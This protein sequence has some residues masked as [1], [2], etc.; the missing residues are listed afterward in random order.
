[1][2]ERP[3]LLWLLLVLLP[4]SLILW[5]RYFTGKRDLKSVGGD[6]LKIE[7]ENVYIVKWFFHAFFFILFVFFAI[8]SLAGPKWGS[9]P[10][11]D[12]RKGQEIL[13]LF[14]ISNSML[15]EDIAP[16]RLRRSAALARSLVDSAPTARYGV[17]GFKGHG[18]LLLPITEDLTAVQNVLESI[19][20]DMISSPG[21]NIELGI[22]ASLDSFTTIFE[23]HKYLVIFTDGEYQTGD[24]VD[25]APSVKD[26]QVDLHVVAIGTDEPTPIPL[27]SGEYM[28]DGSGNILT[29]TLRL[30]FWRLSPLRQEVL[31]ILPQIRAHE[32]TSSQRFP[33]WTSI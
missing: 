2:I 24:P 25:A 22:R 19:G 18:S 13:F 15:A 32:T 23:T 29:S 14:D 7:F 28:T 10:I 26:S 1:M 17:A 33:G 27:R 16:S 6:W 12:E 21:T 4:I 30:D 20:P 9:R 31:S 8:F 3:E 11:P 5:R